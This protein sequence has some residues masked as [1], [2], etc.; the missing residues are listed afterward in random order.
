MSKRPEPALRSA[1]DRRPSLLFGL[2]PAILSSMCSHRGV[3][4]MPG[5]IACLRCRTVLQI[6]VLLCVLG[7]TVGQAAAQRPTKA[8]E[9]ALRSAC[10]SDFM[11]HC[12]KVNP[13]GPGAMACL[14]RNAASLSPGC[15][16]AVSAAS[17]GA[18]PAGAQPVAPPAAAAAPP[19]GAP[20][21]SKAQNNAI[22]SACRSDFIA[23]CSKVNPNGPGAMACLQRNAASLSANCRAAVGAAGGGAA[24]AGVQPALLPAPAGVQPA[25]LPAPAGVQPAG[26]PAPASTPEASIAIVEAVSGRVLG[27]AHG[28]PAL[29]GYSDLISDHTQLDLLANSELRICHYRANRLLTLRGPLRATVTADGVTDESGRAVDG[30]SGT[31]TPP[32]V[33]R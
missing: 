7:L 13:N 23:H 3:R 33:S 12:S 10:R 28:K 1:F 22:R 14:Q 11:R 2:P 21:P 24:P 6:S 32:A 29:L 4:E 9:S 15:R 17:G 26:L 25:G 8:Q 18:A 5:R 31:C 20:Q 27:F 30:A 19:G 16:T